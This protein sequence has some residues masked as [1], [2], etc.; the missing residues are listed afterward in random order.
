MQR[1]WAQSLVGKLRSRMLHSV[2]KKKKILKKENPKNNLT[3]CKAAMQTWPQK[4]FPALG[5]SSRVGMDGGCPSQELEKNATGREEPGRGQPPA[6]TRQGEG[7][8]SQDAWDTGPGTPSAGG[9]TEAQSMAADAPWPERPWQAGLYSPLSCS[10]SSLR[11]QHPLG[12]A[13]RSRSDL[14]ASHRPSACGLWSGGSN[15]SIPAGCQN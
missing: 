5:R 12:A 2:A 11:C 14:W 6:P 8:D 1:E 4:S 15:P 3:P 13:G 9:E 10:W 7:W